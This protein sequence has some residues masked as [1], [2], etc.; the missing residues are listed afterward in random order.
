M[1]SS[2]EIFEKMFAGGGIKINGD[3]P[4]DI[5]VHNEGTY[6][7][8]LGG[9]SIG[10]GEAY[11][12]G[13]WDAEALDE[14]FFRMLYY[15]VDKLI[16]RNLTTIKYA[17]KAKYLNMQTKARSKEVV[18]K[19]YNIGNDIYQ[20]ILDKR[21]LYSCG[22]WKTAQTLDESQ[23]DKLDLICRKLKLEPGMRLL[24]MGCGWGGL[25]Q[26]AAERYGVTVVGITISEEQAV[27]AREVTKGLPVEIKIQD[28][29]D[30]N[31][32]FDRIACV[33]MMEHIGYR[34]YRTL[35]EMVARNLDDEGIFLL[36]TIGGNYSTKVTDP[37][38]DKYIFPNGM[39][40]SAAQI[41]TAA[42]GLFILEDWHNF[43]FYY[44]RTCMEWMKKLE[45]A[46][47]QF[48][49][50]HDMSFYRMWEFYLSASAAS[51]RARK[52]HLWQIVYR[53][54]LSLGLYEAVR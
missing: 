52:N 40:P 9:G 53:K 46:K 6:D 24:D 4:W 39:L 11:M 21:M 27:I 32:K 38:I 51:F 47:E 28:Y 29:R 10:F 12:D 43:G 37:W 44:D 54:P 33:A 30:F 2:K 45:N 8:L 20:T 7:R 49:K 1:G 15:R 42:M 16:P 18:R 34:N 50:D 22:Y 14:F 31:D 41:T 13:W 5:Q 36:H 3:N 17:L 25:S 35:M 23:E 48:V 26:F 19:H